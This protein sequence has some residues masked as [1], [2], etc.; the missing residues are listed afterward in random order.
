NSSND[1]MKVVI[2]GDVAVLFANPKNVSWV[3]EGDNLWQEITHVKA[4]QEYE[5]Q[6]LGS[7]GS[8]YDATLELEDANTIKV[9]IDAG[10][11]GN[12]QEWVRVGA[13]DVLP[14][15]EISDING[16][17]TRI[18]SNNASLDGM[19][20]KLLNEEANVSFLPA[21]AASYTVGDVLWREINFI[22]GGDTFNLEVMGSDGFYYEAKLKRISDDRMELT[23]DA[24]GNGNAQ[25]WER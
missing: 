10:G 25:V 20:V 18:S 11:A 22:P 12:E 4:L 17:W 5:M 7:D 8:Y 24:N 15:C 14:E 9:T 21:S 2:S 19:R 6:V 13:S 16:N 3:D 23:I 1:C